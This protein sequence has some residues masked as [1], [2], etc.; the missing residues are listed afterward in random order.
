DAVVP[1]AGGRVVRVA[2]FLVLLTDGRLEFLLLVLAPRPSGRFE[3]VAVHGGEDGG[4]LF[5]PHDRNAGVG[6]GPQ[7][8]RR[9]G[10]AG[11]GVIARP[12]R[13]PDDD[14]ELGHPGAAK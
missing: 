11:H 3:L 12:E 7:E 13:S 1:H 5:S 6:P 4:S 8:P 9:E 14:R 10:P 2:L